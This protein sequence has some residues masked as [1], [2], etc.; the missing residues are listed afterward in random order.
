MGHGGVTETLWGS[1][2][3]EMQPYGSFN[4]LFV[5]FHVRNIVKILMPSDSAGCRNLVV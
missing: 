5:L 4:I 1:L 2:S 3:V